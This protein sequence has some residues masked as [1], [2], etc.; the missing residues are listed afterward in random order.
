[1]SS[2]AANYRARMASSARL[3]DRERR[4]DD[5]G[6]CDEKE[7]KVF[8]PVDDSYVA[9]VNAWAEYAHNK[10][11][12][13]QERDRRFREFSCANPDVAFCNTHGQIYDVHAAM[14]DPD[15]RAYKV[16]EE[17]LTCDQAGGIRELFPFSPHMPVSAYRDNWIK[18]VGSY[19][20][21]NS[22]NIIRNGN[23]MSDGPKYVAAME[24]LVRSFSAEKREWLM[25]V[26]RIWQY[27]HSRR[28]QIRDPSSDTSVA[29][30]DVVSFAHS[31]MHGDDEK[32]KQPDVD[33]DTSLLFPDVDPILMRFTEDCTHRSEECHPATI[34]GMFCHEHKRVGDLVPSHPKTRYRQCGICLGPRVKSK[35]DQRQEA[36]VRANTAKP[37]GKVGQ[38]YTPDVEA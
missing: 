10:D 16:N 5:D 14:G 33:V 17:C 31:D 38:L 34:A 9:A 4:G 7:E 27:A 26:Q 37:G 32:Q 36:S 6:E 15:K 8:R 2:F 3:G 19:A 21:A 23:A 25:Y 18:A 24:K 12:A 1:M 30:E 20:W 22:S 29:M 11:V 35:M 13:Q 28:T